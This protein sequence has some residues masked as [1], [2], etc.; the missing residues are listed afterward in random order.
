MQGLE[1]TGKRPFDKVLLHG[2]IRDNLGRKMS[3]SLGNGVDPLDIIA[4]Y[5]VDALR[6]FL[7]TSSSPG[8]DL[9]YSNEKV[10]A[11]ANFLNKVWNSA[12]FI[13]LNCED[14][15][16]NAEIN[17]KELNIFDKYIIGKFNETIKNVTKNMDKY[18]LGTAAT[19]LYNFVYDDFCSFYIE[20]TKSYLKNEH[21]KVT[22]KVLIH[23]L[24]GILT[25]IYPYSRFIAEEIYTKLNNSKESIMLETY[26]VYNAR[27]LY[28]KEIEVVDLLKLMIKDIRNY[29]VTNHIAPSKAISV[30]VKGLEL[31]PDFIEGLQSLSNVVVENKPDAMSNSFIYS[32]VELV[33]FDDSSKEEVIKQLN[34]MLQKTEFEITRATKMLGNENFIKKANPQ[35]VQ[36]EKDKLAKFLEQ[37]ENI[38]A[39]Y[40]I[41]VGNML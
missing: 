38:F 26:P 36:D 9:R 4:T 16:M 7:A 12:R 1:F 27:R 39:Q 19:Y 21:A 40:C 20:S 10:E 33:I 25:M 34:E 31:T 28:K 23:V 15:D 41:F 29:K 5:G 3:K 24:K 37:K 11:S 8:L 14:V 18:E 35:K 17:T 30:Y 22:K 6:Y 13:L 32:S 2:L